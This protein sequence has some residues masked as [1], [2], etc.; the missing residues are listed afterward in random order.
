MLPFK[1][2]LTAVAC[3]IIT[4]Q[5]QAMTDN[6]LI[7]EIIRTTQPLSQPRGDRLPLYLWP[8]HNLGT[9]D[10]SEIVELLQQ[11]EARGIAAIATWRPYDQAALD[12]ALRLGTIQQ[13]LGLPIA[14]NANACTYSFFDGDERTAHVDDQGKPFFD[15]SFGH[16]PMG[17]PFALDH[18]L[19]EMRRRLAEPA[20]AYAGAGLE[21][22]FVFAD[23]EIDGP[24]EWNDAWE[25]SRRCTRCR[26]HIPDIEDFTSFQTSLRQIRSAL[27]RQMLAEPILEHHPHALVG[28]Y[29]V[30]PHNGYRYWY[31]Y[32]EKFVQGAPHKIDGRA[33][34]RKWYHE[35][36][37]TGYTFAMP[38]VY[39]WQDIYGWYDFDAPDYRWFYN[40]LKVGSNAGKS[41]PG[42]I[43][44][45]TFVHW[46]TVLLS[47]PPPPG[48]QQFSEEKYQELLWH[49]LLRGHDTLFMWSV[50]DEALKESQLVHQVYAASHEYGDFLL[51]GEPVTFAVPARPGP[52]VSAVRWDGKLLVRRTD[53]DATQEPVEL[54]LEDRTLLIPRKDGQC[55]VIALE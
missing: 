42:D 45:I 33:R 19:P 7:R 46:H 53:F 11:L 50:K 6:E 30:Y 27:Q 40:M 32:F 4:S 3:G 15:P 22:H 24:I 34:Y 47:D 26:E 36:P 12:A 18:R 54:Q 52:V 37:E 2:L 29:A 13:R 21:L 10:E 44:V 9:E 25:H 5:V 8:A 17:C 28:N 55:Q 14:V 49:L 20:A 16:Q 48:L 39:T 1:L 23:W 35:F 31:D 43:P 51:H 38:V 41:T